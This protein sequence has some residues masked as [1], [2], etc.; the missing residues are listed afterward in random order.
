VWRLQLDPD[1][2]FGH[3]EICSSLSRHLKK[4][5][6]ELSVDVVVMLAGALLHQGPVPGN[7]NMLADWLLS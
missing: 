6:D 3:L 1:I 5:P 2:R 4:G 7:Y